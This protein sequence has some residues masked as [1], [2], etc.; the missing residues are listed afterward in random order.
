MMKEENQEEE[1]NVR[2]GG[3]V[4]ARRGRR[5]GSTRRR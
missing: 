3:I 4:R 2:V 1:E 5:D